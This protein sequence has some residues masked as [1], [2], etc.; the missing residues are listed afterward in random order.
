MST[1]AT[2]CLRLAL[3]NESSRQFA[4]VA[5][6]QLAQIA[7]LSGDRLDDGIVLAKQA[8]QV[9]AREVTGSLRNRS[10]VW[11]P[12]TRSSP[13]HFCLNAVFNPV[14]WGLLS[15][16]ADPLSPPTKLDSE[17]FATPRKEINL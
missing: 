12:G 10:P 6:V 4:D 9:D 14:G 1:E 2:G 17:N 16:C 5:L 13:E 8:I 11:S 7:A 3:A 15:H